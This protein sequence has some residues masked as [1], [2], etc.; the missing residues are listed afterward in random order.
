MNSIS[1]IHGPQTVT[2]HRH[3]KL[4]VLHRF[5]ILQVLFP[6][7]LSVVVGHGDPLLRDLPHLYFHF[8]QSLWGSKGGDKNWDELTV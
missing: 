7:L 3:V 4:S 2:L 8:D 1:L 6:N 5:M